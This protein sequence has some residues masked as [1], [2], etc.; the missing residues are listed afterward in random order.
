M[1]TPQAFC[2][3]QLLR[4]HRTLSDRDTVTDDCMLL[5]RAGLRV[6]LVAGSERNLK[7]TTPNDLL[8]AEFYLKK[9]PTE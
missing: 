5:E 6:K 1:Q 7:I 8:L 3:E 4:L 2:R 9:E